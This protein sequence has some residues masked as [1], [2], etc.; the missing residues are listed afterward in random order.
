MNCV[1]CLSA[2]NITDYLHLGNYKNII[3]SIKLGNDFLRIFS[4]SSKAV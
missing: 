2:I 4:I 3:L 1:K